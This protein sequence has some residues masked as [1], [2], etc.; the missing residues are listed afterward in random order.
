MM[1][2]IRAPA[3]KDG[4]SKAGLQRLPEG[5]HEPGF[6]RCGQYVKLGLVLRDGK[7]AKQHQRGL[8][9][10]LSRKRRPKPDFCKSH[11]LPQSNL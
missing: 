1:P 5:A 6:D 7:D 11:V 9:Y 4:L 3:G 2:S 8:A 10:G